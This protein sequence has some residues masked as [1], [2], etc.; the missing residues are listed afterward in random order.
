VVKKQKGISSQSTNLDLRSGDTTYPN[1]PGIKA[2]QVAH[3]FGCVNRPRDVVGAGPNDD[4]IK[5][6][7]ARVIRM[8]SFMPNFFQRLDLEVWMLICS[9]GK[10]F[11]GLSS[12][13]CVA[14]G[15]INGSDQTIQIKTAKL[16]Q[17]RSP[18]YSIP[19]IEYNTNQ[20]ILYPGGAIIL[21]GWGAAPS[22]LQP[23]KVGIKVETNIFTTDFTD[24]ISQS[25]TTEVLPQWQVSFAEKSYDT[26]G[27]WAKYWILVHKKNT[28]VATR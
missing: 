18:C 4:F 6:C 26:S 8:G 21:F 25:T 5:R 17:G 13:R 23:G 2:I 10:M 7:H 27:W 3:I 20:G 19:T 1:L 11:T 9:V 16:L 22:L 14:A 28:L 15:I 24:N 12:R